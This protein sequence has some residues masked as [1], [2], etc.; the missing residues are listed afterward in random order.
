MADNVSVT[1]GVYTATVAT[2]EVTDG[3]LGTVQVQ[4]TKLMDGTLNSTNKLLINSSGEAAVICSGEAAS[5]TT[6]SGNP[7]LMGLSDGT[8]ARSVFGDTSGRLYA[9]MIGFDGSNTQNITVDTSG[10][11]LVVGAAASGAT[12]SGN[13]VPVSACAAGR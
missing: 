9:R 13:P 6:L 4:Y 2:D 1:A 7:V 8:N 11:Q 5:G 10:R 3:T 12:S